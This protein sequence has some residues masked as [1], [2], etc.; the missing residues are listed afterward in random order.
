MI[1][2]LFR[3]DP[4]AEQAL[5]AY[6]I[7]VAQSRQPAFYLD[8]DIKDNVTGRFDMIALHMTIVFHHLHKGGENDKKFAQSLF[9]L[10][11]K[12]M[13]RSL[14]EMG[15]GDITVPKKVKKMGEVFFGLLGAVKDAYESED[16][17]SLA[18]ALDRNLYS[19]QNIESAT[20]LARYCLEQ[21]KHIGTQATV[22]QGE[23]EF[24]EASETVKSVLAGDYA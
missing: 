21:V 17:Q 23:F 1:F 13:D 22:S 14:R 2:S 12:D 4:Y 24:R 11:F 10:F 16:I 20:N 5:A 7:I 9:D 15:V 3:K 19:S 6:N 8:L 18:D